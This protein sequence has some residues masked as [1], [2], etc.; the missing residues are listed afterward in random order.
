MERLVTASMT[1]LTSATSPPTSFAVFVVTLATWPRTVLIV[2]VAPSGATI[3]ATPNPA[4]AEETLQN[5]SI[6]LSW[7]ILAA[8]V[9][10]DHW[11]LAVLSRPLKA[12]PVATT[13]A[14]K[15]WLL[16][17]VRRP[18]LRLGSNVVMTAEQ[19]ALLPGS[20]VAME[21]TATK[22]ATP[23]SNTTSTLAAMEV[24]ME[25][26]ADRPLLGR[27]RLQAAK[28]LGN[29]RLQRRKTM[30]MVVMDSTTQ[31]A[32]EAH[33]PLLAWGRLLA[34]VHL[35]PGS[36]EATAMPV[37]LHLLHRPTHRHHRHLHPR[38]TS[39]RRHLHRRPVP[40]TGSFHCRAL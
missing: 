7:P 21:E 39:R 10:E 1:V 11:A 40:E 22:D 6:R 17:I 8:V 25:A 3:P 34:W 24:G 30:A 12:L 35:R 5:A 38:A 9:V 16:G 23:P 28:R 15:L 18:A 26:T 31:A 29:S 2:L 20:K 32:M 27:M 37:I 4:S 36:R 19:G 13:R 14:A 33:P